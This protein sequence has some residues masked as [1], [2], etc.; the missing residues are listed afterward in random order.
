MGAAG[1][2]N[3]IIDKVAEKMGE[4]AD[5]LAP[6]AETIVDEYVWMSAL[7]AT[8]FL[9]IAI[10]AFAL[11]C[12]LT[13]KFRKLALDDDSEFDKDGEIMAMVIIWVLLGI[14]GCALLMQA[15]LATGRALSPH[16]HIAAKLLG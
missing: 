5:K 13:R 10:M 16:Y 12:Y 11:A 9:L 2:A 3:E 8:G 4:A 1:Q 6:L 15:I 7:E 14:G